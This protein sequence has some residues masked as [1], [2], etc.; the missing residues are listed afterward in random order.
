MQAGG[1]YACGSGPIV[2]EPPPQPLNTE[3]LSNVA[4][5]HVP[6]ILFMVSALGLSLP[7]ALTVASSGESLGR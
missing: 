3:A 5:A 4:G 7:R 1:A 6:R 2:P